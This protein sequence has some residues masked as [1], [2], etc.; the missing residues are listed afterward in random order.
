LKICHQGEVWRGWTDQEDR[1][2]MKYPRDKEVETIEE[3]GNLPD[4]E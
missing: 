3:E 1:K 4:K 2:E